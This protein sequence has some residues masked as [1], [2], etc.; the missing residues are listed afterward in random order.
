M[1]DDLT[2]VQAARLI[3]QKSGRPMSRDGVHKAIDSGALVATPRDVPGHPRPMLF[4]NRQEVEAFAERR[5]M[6]SR[7]GPLTKREQKQRDRGVWDVGRPEK[8]A[9]EN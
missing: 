6:A 7:R 1:P 2:V 8:Q 9:E 4:L 3:A 5:K